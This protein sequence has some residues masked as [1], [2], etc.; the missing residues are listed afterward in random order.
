MANSQKHP[1][2]KILEREKFK[3]SQEHCNLVT[4]MDS[5]FDLNTDATQEFIN[6]DAVSNITTSANQ[7]AQCQTSKISGPGEKLPE[8][9]FKK[10]YF[11]QEYQKQQQQQQ[12]QATNDKIVT[13]PGVR[14]CTSPSEQQANAQKST[15]SEDMHHIQNYAA[16]TVLSHTNYNQTRPQPNH[17][18]PINSGP[19]VSL[20][21]PKQTPNSVN[22]N[23]S[24]QSQSQGQPSPSLHKTSSVNFTHSTHP[25]L[26]NQS[27]HTSS[28]TQGGGSQNM[29]PIHPMTQTNQAAASLGQHINRGHSMSK[30]T[31]KYLT[32]KA[33]H[34]TEQHYYGESYPRHN[35]YP[36]Y[37]QGQIRQ[38]PMMLSAGSQNANFYGSHSYSRQGYPANYRG[39]TGYMYQPPPNADDMHSFRNPK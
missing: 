9:H 12:Q 31:T 5:Q 24:I 1:E 17:D 4:T 22:P 25:V 6:N 34:T 38:D 32:Q 11:D 7:F 2:D 14:N 35:M 21:N 26:I 18:Q 23:A 36:P 29:Q 19:H 10:K 13:S 15:N 30:Q 28:S 39:R 3:Y 27:S 20:E 8:R 37:Q 33:S 16:S